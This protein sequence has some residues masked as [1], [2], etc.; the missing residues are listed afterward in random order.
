MPRD[1]ELT[2]YERLGE[3]G[4]KHALEKP[5]SDGECGLYFQRIGA[6]FSLLP[7]PP[8]RILECGCGSGW[9]AYF[10]ARRGYTVVATDVA[11]DAIDLARNHPPFPLATPPEFVVADTEALPFEAAFDVVLFFDSLHHSVDELAAL[12]CAHRALKPGGLCVALEPGRGHHKKSLQVE[13]AHDVTEKDM[14][15]C[16]V[17]KLGRKVG[18]RR[19]RTLPS[20]QHLSKLLYSPQRP[21]WFNFLGM[22]L[23][24]LLAVLGVVVLRD[25]YC[26]I[27][28][29]HKDPA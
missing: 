20:P 27:T 19:A 2:Y 22:G 10:L 23:V 13:E 28:I 25:W 18:F 26:G 5:F 7:P 17:R 14:P 11:A 12:R 24:R 8:A 9:L 3:A 15:P 16:Y 4:R 1:G 29:L 6:L 21:G